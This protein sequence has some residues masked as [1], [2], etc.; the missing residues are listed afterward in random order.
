L[1]VTEVEDDAFGPDV[2]GQTDH[3]APQKWLSRHECG[4]GRGWV[5][6]KVLVLAG[7]RDTQW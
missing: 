3:T 5:A 6:V 7:I 2:D 4:W 1:S